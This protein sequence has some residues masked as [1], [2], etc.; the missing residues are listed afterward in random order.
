MVTFSLLESDCI[1]SVLLP[2]VLIVLSQDF[3]RPSTSEDPI[4]RYLKTIVAWYEAATSIFRRPPRIPISANLV[5]LPD[6]VI[7]NVEDC[8]KTFLDELSQ[9]PLVETKNF[10]G[11]LDRR[12]LAERVQGVTYHAEAILMG[13]AHSFSP[14]EVEL[15][16][17][18]ALGL[19]HA[20]WDILKRV[21][22]V[23]VFLLQDFPLGH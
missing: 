3:E 22:K 18:R 21:F 4:F 8:I 13:L 5:A 9:H 20:D 16:S 10:P 12:K 6:P 14:S 17:Q 19:N 15:P 7:D 11:Y 23:R 2:F 1:S